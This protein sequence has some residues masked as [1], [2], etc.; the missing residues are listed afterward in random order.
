MICHE[1]KCIFI[2]V[3]KNAGQSVEH[4]F[5]K[6]V[7]LTWKTRAPLLLRANGNPALGPPRL[8][9]LKAHEYAGRNHI[10]QEQ[11]N[12]Y[13]KFAFVR[14][15]WDRMVSFY[16]YMGLRKGQGFKEFLMS[17]FKNDIWKTRQWFVGPQL[18]FICDP[19]GRVAVDFVGRYEQLQA[20]FQKVCQRLN[21]PVN[22]LPHVNKSKG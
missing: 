11:F 7:G 14:N 1:Y 8:A 15:P 2:H 9:H 18:D 21:L 20:D 12:S 3:P 22:E 10:P 19:D 5:L 16:K 4:V 6:L 13:F 17:D